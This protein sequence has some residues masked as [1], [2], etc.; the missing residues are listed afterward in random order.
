MG[1]IID[2]GC[3]NW[4]Q[5][6]LLVVLCGSRMNQAEASGPVTPRARRAGSDR[7]CTR[8][9][10]GTTPGKRLGVI[11]NAQGTNNERLL[12]KD[13]ADEHRDEFSPHQKKRDSETVQVWDCTFKDSNTMQVSDCTV[14]ESLKDFIGTTY[15][16]K[17]HLLFG[18][19]ILRIPKLSVLDLEQH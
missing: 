19:S 15:T 7:Q 17:I 16:N 18:S 12:A 6:Q 1:T 2:L 4:Y 9:R 8:H 3:H 11:G 10:Q 13:L 5:S 14:K